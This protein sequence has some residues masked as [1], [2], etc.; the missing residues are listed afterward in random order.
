MDDKS[1]RT[2]EYAKILDK[3]AG[4]TDF[5]ASTDLAHNL[6]PT[7]K[8]DEAQ[9]RLALTREAMLLLDVKAEAGV[10]GAHD[11]RHLT[12]RA[13][14]SGI[15]TAQEVLDVKATLVS[16]RE[17]YR[18]FERK[19]EQYPN[20]A[21]IAQ[22]LPP[23]PG[24]IEAI[25]R[26]ISDRGE[27]LDSASPKL[28]TIRSQIK[29]A[30]ERLMSKLTHILNDP[31]NAAHLQENI[32]TQRNGRYVVPMRSESRGHL[33]SIVHDQ[34]S[35]GQTVFVEPLVTVDLNN[36]WQEQQLAERDEER[37][38]LTELS[39][40][41]GTF[42]PAIDA[43]VDALARLDLAFACAKY[44]W[45]IHAFEPELLPFQKRRDKHPGSVL[46]LHQARHPLLD[47]AKVVPID[48]VLDPNT[49]S[50]VITGPNTGGKTVSLKTAGLLVVMAQSGLFI[51]AR[52][53][54]RLTVFDNVYA[55]IGDEQSIEQS[56]STFSAHVT[57]IIRILG[58]ADAHS[59]VILDEL[60]AGTDPQ[61]GSALARALLAHLVE[62][63]IT[64]L[65]A[66]HYPELKA[67]AHATP[68]MLNASM[69]FD[70]RTLQPTY[71]LIIGVPGRSNALSI[72]EKLGLPA[73][74]VQSAREM[75]DPTELKA[76][77]L[78][79]EIHHQRKV[80][81]QARGAADRAKF[82]SEKLSKDLA[83]RLDQIEDERHTI[84]EQART[85]Q[86]QEL[87]TLRDELER[88]RKKLNRAGEPVDEVKAAVAQVEQL[89]K[90]FDKPI[91]RKESARQSKRPLKVGDRVHVRSLDMDAT[92]SALG[93][94]EL[95]VVAGP[96]RFKA[97]RRDILRHDEAEEDEQ[98]AAGT[99]R[100]SA[101][102]KLPT[103][104]PGMELDLRG[105]YSEDAEE[106]IIRYIE[107]AY[108]GGMPFVRIIHGKGTGR[109]RQLTRELVRTSQYVSRFES[110]QESEGGDGVTVA[111]IKQ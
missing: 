2:L 33:K 83:K 63:R 36:E 77:D 39:D 10:G 23:P 21:L 100:G 26:A 79:D 90:K 87:E 81:R 67:F 17:L 92:V 94:D 57:N 43:L 15:L 91:L 98:P 66:T 108:L 47:A 80:A 82:E 18:T 61:E 6:R 45:D 7:A 34:S 107:E 109:L 49:Y 11:V 1:L 55:D 22:K 12:D 74:I 44:A 78:L 54:S 106:R 84:L 89:E 41:V 76:E 25:T 105:Q 37:R 27:V 68:G 13:A 110:G 69:E 103:T 31:R 9:A 28:G 93:E 58:R 51:P 86:L 102:V 71:H 104:N 99:G 32:I 40:Q 3:L 62:K 65:V 64:N 8:L 70:L 75:V 72:A 29:I 56:L 19:E 14:R 50:L 101:R 96:L 52:S 20:L 53:G 85:Q 16:A 46:E 95:E 73:E 35:S 24:L 59:L 111:W 48:M 42:A 38:I 5:S 60:G 88:L 4:Y 30:H 97:K